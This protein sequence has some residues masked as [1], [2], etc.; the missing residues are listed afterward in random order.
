[1]R[2]FAHLERLRGE[3]LG[4]LR[5]RRPPVDFTGIAET[6]TGDV[7]EPTPEQEIA[8]QQMRRRPLDGLDEFEEGRGRGAREKDGT[9]V[10]GIDGLDG[11][12][13][14]PVLGKGR[15]PPVR[16]ASR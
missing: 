14:L 12:L 11:R 3:S 15:N 4:R 16:A 8:R 2:A 13:V 5:K 9:R 10:V 1:V 7:P 6:L